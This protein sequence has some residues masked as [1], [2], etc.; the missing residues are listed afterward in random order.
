[1]F[2]AAQYVILA[3]KYFRILQQK[4]LQQFIQINNEIGK[5]NKLNPGTMLDYYNRYIWANQ[6]LIQISISIQSYA[7]YCSLILSILFPFYIFSKFFLWT[8]R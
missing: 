5:K 8:N 3:S 1:M 7:R 2:G 4:I 6:E